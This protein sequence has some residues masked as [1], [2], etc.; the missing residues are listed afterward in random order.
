MLKS[1]AT[2]ITPVITRLFNLSIFSGRFP[3]AWKIASVVPIP[4]SNDSGS[5]SGYRPISLLPVLSKILERH[6]YNLLF[7]HLENHNLLS[8]L[9]WGFLPG[10]SATSALL[11]TIDQWLQQLDKGGRVCAIFLDLKKAFDSVPHRALIDQLHKYNV[12]QYLINWIT[13]YLTSRQQ[14]VVVGG[15]TSPQLQVISGV[16]QGSILGPLLF[17][18]YVND[19]MEL[20]FTQ[21]ANLVSYADDMLLYKRIDRDGDMEDLQV[22]LQCIHQ[23][24]QTKHLLLNPSKCSY[25]IM[26]KWTHQPPELSI[27]YDPLTRVSSVKYLGLTI[28]ESLSWSE[29][30]EKICKKGKKMIGLMYRRFY[31][32]ATPEMLLHLYRS[33][34]LPHLEYAQEVWS[35]HLVR[36]INRLEDTQRLA[37]K[38]CCKCWHD[39]Y[40]TLMS[41]L[42]V[43]T[44]ATRRE[45]KRLITLFK[46]LNGYLVI[47]DG[48]LP[49]ST[50]SAYNIRNSST[51]SVPFAK[52]NSYFYSFF[53]S[54]CRKF[55]LLPYEIQSAKSL[56]KFKSFFVL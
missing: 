53:P 18:F 39:D 23:W 40:D 10:R 43:T 11:L 6:I 34:V 2:S 16:P 31:K 52:H 38:V 54:S 28:N 24:A 21:G 22:D 35:P 5:P 7:E 20:Q 33:M 27:G 3:E 29:H 44:L 17:L 30:I 4:K 56:S 48:V 37:L 13:S 15:T 50:T 8:Q 14:R 42:N 47:P 49:L 41:K 25:M 55:N 19:S 32:D 45:R 26:G 1:T 9:Q 12:D 36:D 51:F 46:F